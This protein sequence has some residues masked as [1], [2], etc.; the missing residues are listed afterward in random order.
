MII[1]LD[2]IIICVLRATTVSIKGIFN[3]LYTLLANDYLAFSIS[4]NTQVLSNKRLFWRI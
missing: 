2:K 3:A 4:G 1:W